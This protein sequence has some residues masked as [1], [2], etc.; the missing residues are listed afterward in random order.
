MA[1]L[2]RAGDAMPRLVDMARQAADVLA[3]TDDDARADA[4]RAMRAP[5]DEA[6]PDDAALSLPVFA[7]LVPP[8]FRAVTF[9]TYRPETASQKTALAAAQKFVR[10]AKLGQPIMLALI[11]VQGTG[12]SHLLYA[13]VRELVAG[14]VGAPALYARPWYRLADE[15]RYGGPAAFSEHVLEPREVRD[16]LWRGRVV[17]L[18]EVRPTA[19]TAFDDTE[20]A[21]WACHCYDQGAAV[22]ITTNVSP[23][24]DVMGPAAASR[25]V[26][27]VVDGP[28][29]RQEPKAKREAAD[30]KLR[31]AGDR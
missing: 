12:K 3:A 10:L 25:F 7:R 16:Q 18:D 14:G 5:P 4:V 21:K 13:A 19:G 1:E 6:S 8:R 29:A 2:T 31:A 22:L 17:L 28:D 20:L 15:L 23:L 26:Q 9:A 11:G 30:H 24:S 27:L